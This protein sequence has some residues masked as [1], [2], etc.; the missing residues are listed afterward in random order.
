MVYAKA[1]ATLLTYI[2]AVPDDISFALSVY[3]LNID[4]IGLLIEKKANS[5]IHISQNLYLGQV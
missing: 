1:G 3:F 4:M 2:K 5:L